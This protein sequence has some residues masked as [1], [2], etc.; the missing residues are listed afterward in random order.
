MNV[1]LRVE[2]RH[3]LIE[4]EREMNDPITRLRRMIGERDN[5]ILN[6]LSDDQRKMWIGLQGKPLQIEWSPWD[7]MKVPFEK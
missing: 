2:A 4:G 6:A 1:E 5:K 3:D 7:L